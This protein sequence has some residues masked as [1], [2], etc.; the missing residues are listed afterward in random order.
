MNGDFD[1]DTR[2]DGGSGVYTAV[3]SPHWEIWGP[4][5][6]YMATIA[7]RAGMA[8]AQIQHPASIYVQFLRPARFD[9]VDARV[10]VVHAGKRAESIRVS[11]TQEGKPVVEA[12]LR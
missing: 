9:R 7:L 1:R 11:I 5:G 12:L 8:E 4:V 2:V 10:D 6:G 3:V